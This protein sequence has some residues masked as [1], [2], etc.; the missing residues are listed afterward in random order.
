MAAVLTLPATD[1]VRV[2]VPAR[3]DFVQLLRS[4]TASVAGRLPLSLDDL[5]DL[6]L[7]VDE[8]CARLLA[9]GEGAR[10]IRLDLRA[11]PGRLELL[12]VADATTEQWPPP[13]VEDTLGWQ[14]LDALTGSVR[15]ERWNGAPAIR[16]VKPTIDGDR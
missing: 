2:T 1:P 8:S 3:A 12:I 6:R 14:V 10:T 7:A 4:V 5:D 11:L 16:L 9:A 15:F 13:A